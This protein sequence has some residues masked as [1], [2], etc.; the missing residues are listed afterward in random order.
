MNFFTSFRTG[1]MTSFRV[2]KTV[3]VA[4][5]NT[6]LVFQFFV[7]GILVGDSQ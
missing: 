6:K 7:F 2:N 4:E 3:I 1:R 5:K